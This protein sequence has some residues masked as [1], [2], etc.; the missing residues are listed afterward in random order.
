MLR[1]ERAAG[2]SSRKASLTWS[3]AGIN[4]G[5]FQNVI[6]VL[7]GAHVH[8]IEF[9]VTKHVLFK[10]SGILSFF[11]YLS[12]IYEHRAEGIVS[13]LPCA[14]RQFVASS[15]VIIAIHAY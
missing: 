4:N 1:Q 11:Q 7:V 9:R 3:A 8:E 6:R 15:H 14:D 10:I 5:L 2:R 13:L 12:A